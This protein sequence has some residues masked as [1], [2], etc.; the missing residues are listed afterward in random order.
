MGQYSRCI[1]VPKQEVPR[2]RGK[3]FSPL[4]RHDY[5]RTWAQ[6]DPFVGATD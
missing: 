6:P 4:T 5:E 3:G 2:F 1:N